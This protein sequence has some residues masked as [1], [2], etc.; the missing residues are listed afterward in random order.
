ME[1]NQNH[2]ED[3]FRDAFANHE[4]EVSAKVWAGVQS[5]MAVQSAASAGAASTV[6]FKAAAVVGLS[7]VVA[8]GA[9][10]EVTLQSADQ[11]TNEIVVVDEQVEAVQTESETA[12]LETETWVVAEPKSV[13]QEMM[14]TVPT[15]VA[16]EASVTEVSFEEPESE[17]EAETEMADN[18]EIP[19]SAGNSP[20]P[21]TENNS[22]S[23]DKVE[24]KGEESSTEKPKAEDAKPEPKEEDDDSE[25]TPSNDN[26]E[27]VCSI[28]MDHKGMSFISPDGDGTNECFSLDGADQAESFHITIWSKDG[29]ELFQTSDPNF[30]WCGTDRF[31]NVVPNRT[32][33][34]FKIDAFDANGV[35]YTK[36][37][38]RGSIQ[39]FR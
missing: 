31:G 28:E 10:N 5:T 24:N 21:R 35:Q 36:S 3:I 14:N 26:E 15:D 23:V 9:V 2:I 29:V 30:S 38:A 12:K 1:N 19:E 25:V 8:I 32:M 6:M 4:M 39:I 17:M 7:T 37:N 34:Y 20:E 27:K 22:P 16:K 18:Q 33:C 11:K 13:E